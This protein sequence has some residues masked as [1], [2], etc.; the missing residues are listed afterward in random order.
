MLH[1]TVGSPYKP[2]T[3]RA[4]SHAASEASVTQNP[5]SMNS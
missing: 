2:T 3:A 5:L 1:G 4:R